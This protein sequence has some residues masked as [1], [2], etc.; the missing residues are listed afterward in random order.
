MELLLG[1]VRNFRAPSYCETKS[2]RVYFDKKNKTTLKHV[3]LFSF[4]IDNIMRNNLR[5]IF[6]K[7]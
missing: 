2:N 1:K 5:L 7:D 3:F 4:M 6:N